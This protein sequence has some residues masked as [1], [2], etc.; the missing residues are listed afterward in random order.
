MSRTPYE[1]MIRWDDAGV[2]KG[3]HKRYLYRTPREGRPDLVEEGLAEP[4]D[5]NE[6]PTSE[7]MN[8]VT[9]EALAQVTSLNS[10]VDTLTGQIAT[11]TAQ[12]EALL[13]QIDALTGG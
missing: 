6:F 7:V 12:N 2:L 8:S 11:L 9:L 5:T 4:L 13:E 10:Q 3:A 1:L